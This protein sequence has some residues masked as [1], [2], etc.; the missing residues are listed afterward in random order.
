MHY[1]K[2]L[3]KKQKMNEVIE[4]G[5]IVHYKGELFGDF[6]DVDKSNLLEVHN[7]FTL[8]GMPYAGCRVI[9]HPFPEVVGAV[10]YRRVEDMSL[11]ESP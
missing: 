3:L 5:D 1:L 10:V 2:K 11:V 8:G 9:R 4:R 6:P 7:L